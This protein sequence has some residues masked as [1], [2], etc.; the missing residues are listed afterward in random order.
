MLGLRASLLLALPL[1]MACF[2]VP[3]GDEII[4]PLQMIT[5]DIAIAL[6]RWSG[7]PRQY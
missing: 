6:T 1:V 2:L 3:F 5:A 7:V 4:P